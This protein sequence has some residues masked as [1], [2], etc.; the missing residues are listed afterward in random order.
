MAIDHHPA[1]HDPGVEVCPH[2]P[3]HSSVVC[4][5]LEPVD[6]DVVV[7]P[8]KELGQVYVHHHA[9]TRLDELACGFDRVVCSSAGAKPVAVLAEGG[10]DQGL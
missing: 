7:D 9:F 3:D 6:Q 2:Q 5:L 10:V 1:I 4:A 8:V